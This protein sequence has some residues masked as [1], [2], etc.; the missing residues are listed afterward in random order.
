LA[1]QKA[2]GSFRVGLNEFTGN[3]VDIDFIAHIRISAVLN[4]R[5]RQRKRQGR[6][7]ADPPSE[8][9]GCKEDPSV[10]L[11]YAQPLSRNGVKPFRKGTPHTTSGAA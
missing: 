4:Q 10:P 6:I 8:H 2:K 1:T 3:L 7:V 9:V 11:G 5:L